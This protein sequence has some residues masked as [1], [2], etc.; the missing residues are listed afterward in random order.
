MFEVVLPILALQPSTL[1]PG[2]GKVQEKG[3]IPRSATHEVVSRDFNRG[4]MIQ[5]DYPLNVCHREVSPTQQP[6]HDDIFQQTRTSACQLVC[7]HAEASVVTDEGPPKPCAGRAIS[8]TIFDNLSAPSRREKSRK[9][10][11]HFCGC[12]CKQDQCLRLTRLLGSR[13][14]PLSRHLLVFDPVCLTLSPHSFFALACWFNLTPYPLAHLLSLHFS[15]YLFI[16]PSSPSPSLSLSL[17]SFLN[18]MPYRP[19]PSRSN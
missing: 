13:A 1:S 6:S 11:P 18:L 7:R 12:R 17:L 10:P 9:L 5:G 19:T 4:R 2:G 14:V 3:G 15:I 8:L 16:S